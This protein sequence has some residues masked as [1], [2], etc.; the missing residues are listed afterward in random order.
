MATSAVAICN[1]A[2]ARIGNGQAIS[3][4]TEASAQAVLLNSIYEATRDY[5]LRDFPWPFAKRTVVLG[6]VAEDP[7][8]DWLYSYRVPADCIRV[9]RI[10]SS[11]GRSTTTGVPFEI[12]GDDQGGLILTDQATPY[13]DYTARVTSESLFSSDF[14]SVFAWRLA[15]DAAVALSVAPAFTDRAAQQYQRE[16]GAARKNAL[17]ERQDDAPP[18]SSFITARG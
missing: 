4:L 8:T 14:V 17:Q 2:L 9:R 1:L 13:I 18:E 10:L 15:F 3:A 6:L 11:S 5:V 16:L 12:A 7:S